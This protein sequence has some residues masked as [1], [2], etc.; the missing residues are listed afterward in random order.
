MV[1]ADMDSNPVRGGPT[2][3]PSA[4]A[5]TRRS[6]TGLTIAVTCLAVFMVFL[7]IT[8]VNVAFPS[9][10]RSFPHT[11]LPGLSWVLSGYSIVFAALLVPFGRITDVIGDRRVFGVG[12]MV[13]VTASGLCAAAPSV[14]LLVLARI[15]QAVGAAAVV[16]AAQT[17]LMATVS[18]QRRSMAVAFLAAAGAI[19]AGCGPPAAGA[20][21][22]AWSWRLVFLINVPLGIIALALT[23]GLPRSKPAGG[24]TPDLLGAGLVAVGIACFALALVEGGWWGWGDTRIFGAFL[25]AAV[26]IP[27]F[28]ARCARHSAPVLE[29]GLLRVRT[30][31]FGNAASLILG[32]SFYALLLGNALFLTTVWR[33]SVLQ[34]G[35]AMA[36]TPIAAALAAVIAGAFAT[37]C[38]PRTLVGAGALLLTAGATWFALRVPVT[39]QFWSAWVPGAVLTGIGLGL[40]YATSASVTMSRLAPSSFGVGSGINAMMRQLGAVLGVALMVA[41][42]GHPTIQEA[43]AAFDRGWFVAALGGLAALALT[44]AFASGRRAPFVAGASASTLLE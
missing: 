44:I 26:L 34:T 40:S 22:I 21:V 35:L 36:P 32:I 33:W 24:H 2:A 41:A 14:P 7:D 23:R 11:S 31:A 20:V 27:V 38:D 43:P 1:V 25:A 6:F 13:F 8:V 15:A 42:L 12:L 30:F 29:L 37:R 10:R 3:A 19:A 18:S 17:L 39:P 28:I 9:V 16:P 4:S 5:A